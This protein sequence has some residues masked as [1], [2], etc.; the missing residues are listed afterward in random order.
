MIFDHLANSTSVVHRSFIPYTKDT[1]LVLSKIVHDLVSEG[2]GDL[3]PKENFAEINRILSLEKVTTKV[4]DS[5]EQA[6]NVLGK[7]LTQ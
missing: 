2:Q 5:S 3:I 1:F 7:F 6:S 4:F